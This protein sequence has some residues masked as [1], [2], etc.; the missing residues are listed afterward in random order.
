MLVFKMASSLVL[1]FSQFCVNLLFTII[2]IFSICS[3]QICSYSTV[4]VCQC[5]LVFS[6]LLV[7]QSLKSENRF[8]FSSCHQ[9]T[10]RKYIRVTDRIHGLLTWLI[11]YIYLA[12]SKC[13]I[14]F[15]LIKMSARTILKKII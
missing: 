10:N 3:A 2:I 4:C 6:I 12:F 5:T 15:K 8:Y 1:Q 7:S 9:P 11:K 13:H 14:T